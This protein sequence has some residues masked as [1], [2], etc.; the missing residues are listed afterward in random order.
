MEWDVV[1]GVGDIVVWGAVIEGD[2][3]RS[4]GA[5]GTCPLLD[6]VKQA[7]PKSNILNTW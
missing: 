3:A 2:S 1:E 4:L 7:L 5:S 6:F